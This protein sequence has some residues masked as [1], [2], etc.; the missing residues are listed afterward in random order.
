MQIAAPPAQENSAETLEGAWQ[1][2][3]RN[4][5]RVEAGQWQVSSAQ[6]SCEAAQA[7]RLPSLTLGASYYALSDQPAMLASVAPLSR[8]LQLPFANRDMPVP[9]AS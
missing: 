2:A 7:E 9:R 6:N 5:Q 3:L 8:D 4:D 1:I